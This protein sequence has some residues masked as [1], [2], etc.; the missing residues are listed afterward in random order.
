ML[1]PVLED[2]HV[3]TAHKGKIPKVALTRQTSMA[4][5]N[6]LENALHQAI[7]EEAYEDAARFRDEIQAYKK[8]SECEAIQS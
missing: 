1:Q 2:M 3:G 6:D 4:K 7:A 8:A 5:L